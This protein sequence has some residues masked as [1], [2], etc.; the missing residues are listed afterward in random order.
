MPQGALERDH[1]AA[2]EYRVWGESLVEEWSAVRKRDPNA[3]C[4]R[5]FSILDEKNAERHAPMGEREY[6]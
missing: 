5:V 3:S 6:V 4:G 1:E 2:I